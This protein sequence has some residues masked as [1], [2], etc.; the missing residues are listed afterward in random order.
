MR[1]DEVGVSEE[2]ECPYCHYPEA[3]DEYE[4]RGEYTYK[5]KD[6][7]HFKFC[8]VCGWMQYGGED[9][10]SGE[11]TLA[12]K[13]K[14]LL[15]AKKIMKLYNRFF[16]VVDDASWMDEYVSFD[17]GNLKNAYATYDNFM[18]YMVAFIFKNS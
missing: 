5:G 1:L 18:K 2:T 10:D 3:S 11:I 14:R 9:D 7:Q 15:E 16:K 17:F 4:S 12:P 13:E 8:P 6:Y